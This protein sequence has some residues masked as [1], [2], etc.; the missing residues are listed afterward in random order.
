MDRQKALAYIADNG[1]D[2]ACME[3]EMTE[4]FIEE[5]MHKVDMPIVC[6]YQTLSEDF[7]RKHADAMYWSFVSWCQNFSK[8]FFLEFGDRMNIEYL[9]Q[10]TQ[11][12]FLDDEDMQILRDLN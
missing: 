9:F 12:D 7:M 6:Y 3:L 11:L 4:D 5:Y 8:D 1:W 10:N 2:W